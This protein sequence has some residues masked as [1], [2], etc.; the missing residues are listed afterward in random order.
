[1]L[2]NNTAISIIEHHGNRVV[3]LDMIDKVHQRPIGTARA[4]FN[5]NR[6]HFISGKHFFE[7]TADEI[8]RHKTGELRTSNV[9]SSIGK[10][11][12]N[13][14]VFTETG[15]LMIVKPMTD[16]LSWRVQSE[17]VDNY[18]SMKSRLAD[19]EREIFLRDQ[20]YFE[21]WPNDRH[22]RS[23]AM[24]GEPYW[25]IGTVIHRAA[26]TVGKS[27]R[28]MIRWRVMDEQRLKIARIGA[29]FIWAHRRKYRQQLQLF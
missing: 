2:I 3:T 24:R 4:S 8:R 25:Y 14:L 23:M 1:M 20:A 5:R 27:V 22:I 10:N 19:V 28:R 12:R 13:L 26:S 18:F 6:K 16:D 17:L 9:R 7:L 21:K 29:H 11:T 15:Y